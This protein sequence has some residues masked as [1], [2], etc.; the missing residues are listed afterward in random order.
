MEYELNATQTLLLKKIFILFRHISANVQIIASSNGLNLHAL[1]G[2]NSAWLHIQLGK[3]FFR[4]I[5]T[6]GLTASQPSPPYSEI[7]KFWL[8]STKNLCQA[9]TIVSPL[10][11]RNQ[12]YSAVFLKDGGHGDDNTLRTTVALEKLI[13]REEP[14]HGNLLS[15]VMCC[16]EEHIERS[17]IICYED[18]K[19]SV[20]DDINWLNWH[21]LRIQPTVLYK[22]INPYWSPF[23]DIA[24]TYDTK[25]DQVSFSV[26]KSAI[27]TGSRRRKKANKRAGITG[28]I[29]I[30]GSHFM[31]LKFDEKIK[32]PKDVTVS[33]KELISLSSFCESVK[34][35]LSFVVRNPGDP[36]IV[37][38][39]EAVDIADNTIGEISIHQIIS[40]AATRKNGDP[41]DNLLLTSPN[42]AWSGS[43]WLSSIQ[44]T[45]DAPEEP[46]EVAEPE[47]ITIEESEE[48]SSRTVLQSESV[49]EGSG[50][51][52]PRVIH[53]TYEED[54]TVDI[55]DGPSQFGNLTRKQRDLI[56]KTLALDFMP[57]PSYTFNTANNGTVTDTPHE[58]TPFYRSHENPFTVP[59]R[60]LNRGER[61]YDQISGIW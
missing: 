60:E 34:S 61:T 28:K 51:T 50:D 12:G 19:V 18:R 3:D 27:S 5:D 37:V 24:I 45:A 35:P 54:D 17:A 11:P 42:K 52:V 21:Y 58:D 53:E 55:V 2:S 9:L 36:V 41:Y 49:Q 48:Y 1:N 31:Q 22:S 33:L 57:R 47:E 16:A 30:N 29:T 56:Y 26:V 7:P 25:K 20:P 43:L 38:F 4:R 10:G 40:D 13:I 32:P 59:S 39:G 8:L 14:D 6:G 23:D 15:F 44:Q 46:Q